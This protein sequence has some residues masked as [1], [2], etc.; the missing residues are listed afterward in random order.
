TALPPLVEPETGEELSFTYTPQFQRPHVGRPK[1]GDLGTTEILTRQYPALF[2]AATNVPAFARALSAFVNLQHLHISCPGYD[3]SSRYRRSVVDFALIS[4]RIAVE[5]SRLNALDSLTLSPIHPGGL[6]Y[7]TPAMG[8][9]ATLRSAKAWTRIQHLTLHT[10]SV[11]G[12]KDVCRPQHL[13]ILE[14]Y[15]RSF[16]PGL[17][18]LDF[19]WLRDAGPLPTQS[20]SASRET[21][22]EH[23]ANRAGHAVDTQRRHES[24]QSPRPVRFPRLEKVKVKN[25]ATPSTAIKSFIDLHKPSL[26]ELDLEATELT[27]G[28][29][30]DALSPLTRQVRD[31]VSYAHIPIMLSPTTAASSLPARMERVESGEAAGVR[32]SFRMSKWLPGR[33]GR[34]SAAAAQK[35]RGGGNGCEGPLKRVWGGMLAWKG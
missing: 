35:V 24:P 26:Q 11:P 6:H 2:H 10:A 14:T 13:K 18:T 17:T 30:D 9:G 7:L 34:A 16:E 3:D 33:R 5:R 25:V 15:L 8:Y 31:R 28:T 21:T 29:W 23:P 32:A 20:E 4:L 19:Q 1:Y 27:S 22:H 12:A